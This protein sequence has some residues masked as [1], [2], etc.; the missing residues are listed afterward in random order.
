[1]V[2]FLCQYVC[3]Q[4]DDKLCLLILIISKNVLVL[5]PSCWPNIDLL[6]KFPLEAS[7]ADWIFCCSRQNNCKSVII[8]KVLKTQLK[9]ITHD[10]VACWTLQVFSDYL[11]VV[12]RRM[13]FIP[14]PLAVLL[15]RILSQTVHISGR[16]GALLLF[17]SYLWS[18][19]VAKVEKSQAD[20]SFV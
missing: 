2:L 4:W 18:V 13:G 9:T 1:M 20:C 19:D 10:A 15:V 7:H 14:L 8:I 3:V 11:G 5:L 6:V 17:M 16:Q 12:S